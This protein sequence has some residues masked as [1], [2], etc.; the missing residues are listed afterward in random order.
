MKNKYITIK[1]ASSILGVHPV[2]LRRWTN[3]G[4][5]KF[6]RH[7][8]NKYRLFNINDIKKLKNQIGA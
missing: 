1:E 3:Q 2:T 4:L 8:I 5:I 6:T 7:P